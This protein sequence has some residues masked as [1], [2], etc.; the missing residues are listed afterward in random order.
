M[1]IEEDMPKQQKVCPLGFEIYSDGEMEE[2]P[3]SSGSGIPEEWFAKFREDEE[4]E[5]RYWVEKQKEDRS[6][7]DPQPPCPPISLDI[8]KINMRRRC[9]KKITRGGWRRSL[10]NRNTG[11][12]EL[13]KGTTR[14]CLKPVRLVDTKA[15]F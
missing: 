14:M 5:I 15:A 9:S 4:R 12:L 6:L 7:Q 2:T 3:T 1:K 11:P 13:L 10:K 8:E